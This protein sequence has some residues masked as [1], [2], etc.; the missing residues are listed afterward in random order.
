MKRKPT[1]T[2]LNPSPP[3]YQPKR[4]VIV[5]MDTEAEQAATFER[6]KALGFQRLRVVTA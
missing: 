6:L 4:G 2:E 5:M 3:G 1:E